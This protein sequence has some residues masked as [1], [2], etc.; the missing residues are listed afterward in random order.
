MSG[1]DTQPAD[2]IDREVALGKLYTR[3]R[4]ALSQ[5]RLERAAELAGQVADIAPDTTSS[6]EL[7]GDVAMGG[8]LYADARRW[9]VPDSPNFYR[10]QISFSKVVYRMAEFAGRLSPRLRFPPALTCCCGW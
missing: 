9:S 2:D 1:P 8:K 6:E 10:A 5:G 7:L 3:A 4:R